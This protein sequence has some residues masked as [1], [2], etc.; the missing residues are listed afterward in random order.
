MRS[1]CKVNKQNKQKK[2]Q[3]DLEN[4]VEETMAD[5]PSTLRVEAARAQLTITSKILCEMNGL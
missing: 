5:K 3:G 4:S 2:K 1:G